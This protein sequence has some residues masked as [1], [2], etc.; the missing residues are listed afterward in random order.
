MERLLVEWQDSTYNRLNLHHWLCL[1]CMARKHM[2]YHSKKS[3]SGHTLPARDMK[4]R[5]K[6][7]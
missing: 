4:V 3:D 2:A 7:L 1:K 5:A 6:G